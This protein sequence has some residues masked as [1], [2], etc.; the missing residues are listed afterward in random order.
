MGEVQDQKAH[1]S[2]REINAKGEKQ[3]FMSLQNTNTL[4]H[5]CTY[6]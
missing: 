4:S 2:H 6:I 5:R 1:N 3:K